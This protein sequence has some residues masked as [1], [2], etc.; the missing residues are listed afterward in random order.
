MDNNMMSSDN[1]SNDNSLG[2]GNKTKFII[3]GQETE[4]DAN[5]M[6]INETEEHYIVEIE[7]L[8][9]LSTI[10]DTFQ[11]LFNIDMDMCTVDGN[12]CI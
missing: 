10:P 9:V 11:G 8:V 1:D 12:C 2:L 6:R 5:M 4:H 3:L 7:P